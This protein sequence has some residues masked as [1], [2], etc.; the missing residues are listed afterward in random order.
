MPAEIKNLFIRGNN[1]RLKANPD[2]MIKDSSYYEAKY[3]TNTAADI[4]AALTKGKYGWGHEINYWD[5]FNGNVCYFEFFAHAAE[6]KYVDNFL[7]NRY[8]PEIKRI[9]LNLINNLLK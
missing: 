2:E 8:I 4:V 7:I 3:K 6:V 1:F 5:S 9:Q